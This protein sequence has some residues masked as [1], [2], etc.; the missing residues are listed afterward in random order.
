MGLNVCVNK[1]EISIFGFFMT[2]SLNLVET[3]TEKAQDGNEEKESSTVKAISSKV[4]SEVTLSSV[5]TT[6]SV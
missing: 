3:S 6:E 2:K 5:N 1:R 4:S